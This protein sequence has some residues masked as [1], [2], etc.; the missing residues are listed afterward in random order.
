MVFDREA[1]RRNDAVYAEHKDALARGENRVLRKTHTGE[2]HSYP[3]DEIGFSPGRGQAQVR[4]WWG[5]GILTAVMALLFV[6]SWWILLAPLAAGDRPFWGA[7][8][9]T[10]LTALGAWYMF[11]VARDEYRAAKVRK[12]RGSPTPG[13]GSVS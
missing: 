7:L 6:T 3:A 13:G 10:T 12:V 2:L 11:G 9:L 4:T 8:V 1:G 5:M